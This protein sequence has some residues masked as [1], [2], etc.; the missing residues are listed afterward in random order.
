MVW[1]NIQLQKVKNSRILK[2]PKVL[3]RQNV[4][5]H[6]PDFDQNQK[7]YIYLDTLL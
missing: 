2:E 4:S 1:Y 3:H 5:I 6:D 7:D